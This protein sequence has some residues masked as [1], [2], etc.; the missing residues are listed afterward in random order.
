METQCF[1]E[2]KGEVISGL[3]YLST[4][5]EDVWGSEGIAASF[6][7]SALDGGDWSTSRPCRFTPGEVAP[8]THSKGIWVGPRADLNGV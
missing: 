5:H 6:V 2:V 4:S 1:C 8:G 7:T 3:N